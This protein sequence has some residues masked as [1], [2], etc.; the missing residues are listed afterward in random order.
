MLCSSYLLDIMIYI[1]LL[2]WSGE[3]CLDD[4]VQK[5]DIALS[6]VNLEKWSV[7]MG[8]RLNNG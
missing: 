4:R 1:E 7:V 8:W 2:S 3:F 5:Q 6:S